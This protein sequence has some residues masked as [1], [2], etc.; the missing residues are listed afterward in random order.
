M[1]IYILV[2]CC[3]A[4]IGYSIQ[5]LT[6]QRSNT[7][8]YVLL[9]LVVAL[10]VS[11]AGFRG[12]GADFGNYTRLYKN[13][14]VQTWQ[15]LWHS[16]ITFDEPGYKLLCYICSKIYDSPTTMFFLSSL[17]S[18]AP[19][20]L[21]IYKEKV[22]FCVAIILYFLL[23]WTGTFGAVRQYLAAAMI[24]C[25]YP[26]LRERKFW[27]YCFFVVLGASF[28]ITALIMLPIYFLVTREITWKNTL[29]IIIVSFVLR[30]SYDFL[31]N[32]LGAIKDKEFGEYAYLTTG[33]NI[34]RIL[35][36]FAPIVLFLFINCYCIITSFN[37]KP[38]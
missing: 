27:K 28:H 15:T 36:A 33:V 2:F 32:L 10:L 7:L 18:I 13:L 35:I 21:L 20:I 19:C 26:Y 29:L 12:V 23:I 8:R 17:L 25:A 34:F 1:V 14:K 22:P 11:V 38:T 9:F 5:Q 24:F 31:F 6:T 37:R 3:I 4:L 16:M 30:Y